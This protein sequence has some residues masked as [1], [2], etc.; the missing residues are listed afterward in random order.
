MTMSQI[1]DRPP[2]LLARLARCERCGRIAAK[3]HFTESEELV[4][5]PCLKPAC[6]VQRTFALGSRELEERLV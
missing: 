2:S 1:T 3:L 4:C 5:G 6:R